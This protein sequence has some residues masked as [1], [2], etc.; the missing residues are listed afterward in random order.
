MSARLEVRLSSEVQDGRLKS[1]R[2]YTRA[3]LARI[4]T[5]AMLER[6]LEPEFSAE[7]Q[8][9]LAQIASTGAEAGADIRDLT[10]RLWCSIDNDNS[11]DL[12]QFTVCEVLPRG[13]V[14]IR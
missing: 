13:S 9:Q 2:F 3:N 4:A 8:Q 1:G 12:D 14:K 5:D 7:V 6:R 10:A 11:C